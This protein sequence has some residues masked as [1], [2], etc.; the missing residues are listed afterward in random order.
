M[1]KICGEITLW[2]TAKDYRILIAIKARELFLRTV[3]TGSFRGNWNKR[4]TIDEAKMMES[5]LQSLLYCYLEGKALANCEDVEKIEEKT[6]RIIEF[7]GGEEW[8]HQFMSKAPKEDREKT[9]EN[10]AKVKFFLETMLGL[11]TRFNF[12][13]INDPIIGI[14]VKVG[15]IMSVSKHPSADSLMICNVNVGDRALKIVTNDLN[16]KEGN[17]VGVSMLPPATFMGVVSEGMFLGMNGNILKDVQGELGG[18]PSGIP[19]ESLN[20]TKNMIE[21]FLKP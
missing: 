19:M 20:E 10:I 13:P 14:D 2:D 4:A 18:M 8:N 16:V 21:N 15:E 7:L 11:R 17:T 12:G 9:E 3:E 1:I 6:N 5:D